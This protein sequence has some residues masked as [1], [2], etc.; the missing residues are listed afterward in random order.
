MRPLD[1]VP[2]LVTVTAAA[3]MLVY[4]PIEQFANYHDLADRRVVFGVP[5]AG[6][7]LSN[8]GFAVVGLWGLRRLWT[9]RGAVPAPSLPGYAL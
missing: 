2:T 8:A 3:A 6:D 7:V 9:S 4:G 5:Y 1:R